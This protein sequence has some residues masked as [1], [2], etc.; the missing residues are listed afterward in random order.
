MYAIVITSDR[1][2]G[3]SI[4]GPF[5]TESAAHIYAQRN[6]IKMFLICRLN[7]SGEALDTED[8]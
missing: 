2:S 3:L 8:K 4:Y 6:K 1:K 5:S 7:D